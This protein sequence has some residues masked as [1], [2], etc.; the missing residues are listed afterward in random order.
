MNARALDM[1]ITEAIIRDIKMNWKMNIIKD[2]T[3]RN[4]E[5]IISNE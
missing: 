1:G 2:S 5:T 3:S 4:P